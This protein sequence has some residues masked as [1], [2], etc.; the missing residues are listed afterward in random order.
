MYLCDVGG[1]RQPEAQ[2]SASFATLETRKYIRLVARELQ[3]PIFLH[4]TNAATVSRYHCVW[5]SV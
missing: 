2:F 4:F 5:L 3:G 1:K